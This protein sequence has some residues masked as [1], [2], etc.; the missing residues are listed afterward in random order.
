[1][2]SQANLQSHI[3]VPTPSEYYTHTIV[4]EAGAGAELAPGV[5]ASAGFFIEAPAASAPQRDQRLVHAAQSGC[6]TAFSEL[7]S[8]YSRRI[9]RTILAITKNPEDAEDAMQES[10]LRAFLAINRFEGRANFYSW[11][12]RIAINSALL[13]LR[14]RRARPELSLTL[15]QEG[16]D[17]SA[18]LNFKDSAPDPEE[19]CA[20]RQLQANLMRAIRRLSPNLREVVRVRLV[21]ECSVSEVADKLNISEA[22]AKSR[23]YRA[24]RRLGILAVTH[25]RSKPR[26]APAGTSITFTELWHSRGSIPSIA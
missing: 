21:E 13:T 7:F 23:L 4:V 2:A 22:A 15:T 10:F 24:R 9:H 14:K 26:T 20:Y 18:C 1:M 5:T 8:L 25:N 12:T 17:E 19:V 3:A 11:L 16:S 6:R